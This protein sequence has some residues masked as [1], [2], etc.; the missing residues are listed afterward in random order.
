MLLVITPLISPVTVALVIPILYRFEV[1]TVNSIVLVSNTRSDWLIGPLME[2]EYE[3][4][5][6]GIVDTQ[7]IIPNVFA[8]S[9]RV[10]I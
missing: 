9:P 8:G 1:I 3:I 7:G 4:I 2:T 10:C 5:H 6:S